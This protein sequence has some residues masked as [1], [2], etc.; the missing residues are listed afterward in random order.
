MALPKT[1]SIMNR[2]AITYAFARRVF[3]EIYDDD[4]PHPCDIVDE[5]GYWWLIRT[6]VPCA[7]CLATRMRTQKDRD[8]ASAAWSLVADMYDIRLGAER[9]SARAYIKAIKLSPDDQ[10]NWE[11]LGWALLNLHR[12]KLAADVLRRAL[13]LDPK[14]GTAESELRNATDLS[15]TKFSKRYGISK[16]GRANELLAAGRP[17]DALTY[18]ARRRSAEAMRL[19]CVVYGAMNDHVRYEREIERLIKTG[20]KYDL[21]TQTWFAIP[22][23]TLRS[24]RWPWMLYRMTPYPAPTWTVNPDG[25]DDVGLVDYETEDRDSPEWKAQLRRKWLVYLQWRSAA[26]RDDRRAMKKLARKYPKFTAA[27]DAS[28][29][30]ASKRWRV[31]KKD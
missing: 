23:L 12:R 18:L 14:S 5:R 15:D 30:L 11:F 24:R 3:E 7:E 6:M 17:H 9:A 21:D 8:R 4:T 22:F 19:R 29:Y 25:L 1:S 27:R 2:D 31:K 16:L 26:N 10:Q 20:A 28:M 13:E